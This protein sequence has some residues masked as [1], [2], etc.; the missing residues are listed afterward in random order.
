MDTIFAECWLAEIQSRY[1]K[2]LFS[3]E[4]IFSNDPEFTRLRN[5]PIAIGPT[6]PLTLLS[7]MLRH[8]LDERRRAHLFS[9]PFDLGSMKS[10]AK[11]QLSLS[12][13]AAKVRREKRLPDDVATRKKEFESITDAIKQMTGKG[14]REYKDKQNSLRVIYLL[15]KLMNAPGSS[16]EGRNERILTFIKTPAKTFAFEMRGAY[17]TADSETNSFLLND[18]RAYLG[19]EIDLD[20]LTDV[21]SFFR[22]LIDRVDRIHHLLDQAAYSAGTHEGIISSYQCLISHIDHFDVPR[23]NMPL[24]SRLD[25]ELYLHLH[26]VEFMHFAGALR[27]VY[28]RAIPPSSIHPIREDMILAFSQITNHQRTYRNITLPY[29]RFDAFEEIAKASRDY[30]LEL[31][32]T[33][34]GV[35]L[36]DRDYER[37]TTLAEELLFR[38]KFF[39]SESPIDRCDIRVNFREITSSLCAVAQALK[40]RTKYRPNIF[41]DTGQTRSIITPLERRLDIENLDPKY[42]IQEGYLQLWHHRREWVQDALEGHSAIASLKFELRKKLLDKVI[43]CVNLNDIEAIRDALRTLETRLSDIRLG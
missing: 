20:T 28:T 25:L 9:S 24:Q 32:H 33:S 26:K 22:S 15:D 10:I 13:L 3:T 8:G 43:D 27:N 4:F 37:S 34:M 1:P 16:K 18:L 42:A 30:F 23:S 19:I 12:D 7:V 40:F 14:F 21:D 2:N 39:A 17:P 35:I 38:V 36:S 5:Q 29:F 6:G 41:R 31:I 11:S